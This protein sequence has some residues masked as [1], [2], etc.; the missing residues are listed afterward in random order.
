MAFVTKLFHDLRPAEL[1]YC[2]SMTIKRAFYIHQIIT[3]A[4]ELLEES[5]D[6]LGKKI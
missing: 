5:R 3:L 4:K 1:Q 6:A 2:N